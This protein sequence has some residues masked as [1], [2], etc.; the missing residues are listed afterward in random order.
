MV[1]EA[2]RVL[3]V[4]VLVVALMVPLLVTGLDAM[5][6]DAELVVVFVLRRSAN[7]ARSLAAKLTSRSLISALTKLSASGREL[8]LA[9]EEVRGSWSRARA[10]VIN[11]RRAYKKW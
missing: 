10:T 3:M 4:T 11:T 9:E 2:V 5:T 1:V 7:L 8:P 6:V